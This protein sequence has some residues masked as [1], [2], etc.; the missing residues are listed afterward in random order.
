[1]LSRLKLGFYFCLLVWAGLAH[2]HSPVP[3]LISIARQ[4]D[5]ALF[6]SLDVSDGLVQK[7]NG[8]ER[9][10]QYV[11]MSVKFSDSDKQPVPMTWTLLPGDH[12]AL[13]QRPKLADHRFMFS[14]RPKSMPSA[15]HMTWPETLGDAVLQ[16]SGT[17]DKSLN[18]WVRGGEWT[19]A[20]PIGQVA[21]TAFLDFVLV[22]IQHIIPMGADHILFVIGLYLFATQLKPLLLQVSAFTLAHTLTLFSVTLKLV[23]LDPDIVEPLIAIS[24]SYV[25]VEGLFRHQI[26]Q[27]RLAVVF[28]FGLIHGMGFAATLSEVGIRD[29]TLIR[30]LIAFNIGVE[31][32]QLAV[33]LCMYLL[34]GRWF[35]NSRYWD[36]VIKI[37][38]SVAIATTGLV[39]AIQ[40]L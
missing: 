22:G 18:L 34:I 37:P 1:M 7:V 14:V 3:S 13:A 20:L 28:G 19:D 17:A 21:N 40:R 39:W 23:S 26:T 35:S 15:L 24:I 11:S 29:E 36:K 10:A 32:G 12:A 6:V 38:L 27:S 5:G 9:F 8:P 30:D 16:V 25:A 4:M 2:G 31:L 33:V